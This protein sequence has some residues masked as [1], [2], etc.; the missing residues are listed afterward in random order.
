M[1]A[2]TDSHPAWAVPGARVA[3]IFSTRGVVVAVRFGTITKTLAR[4]AVVEFV[5][6][7]EDRWSNRSGIDRYRRT[8]NDW[9]G[10]ESV[11]APADGDD[12]KAA[13]DYLKSVKAARAVRSAYETFDKAHGAEAKLE[14]LDALMVAVQQ[15]RE[16]IARAAEG[17][18]W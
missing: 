13:I 5:D 7:D 16:P 9:S 14:T 12:V 4:D 15:A 11:L 18:T 8:A 2:T 17:S 1:S 3:G 10:H 6:R